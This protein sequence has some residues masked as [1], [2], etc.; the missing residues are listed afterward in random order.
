MKV[1]TEFRGEDGEYADDAP[2]ERV[3][4]VVVTLGGETM[5]NVAALKQMIDEH[6]YAPRGQEFARVV[7]RAALLKWLDEHG[8]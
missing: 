6:T 4:T 1:N 3:S 7:S 2:T 8:A 5:V